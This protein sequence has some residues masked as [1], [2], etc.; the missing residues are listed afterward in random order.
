MV[1]HLPLSEMLKG[2]FV[3]LSTIRLRLVPLLNASRRTCIES[4][5]RVGAL[6]PCLQLDSVSNWRDE[7]F[8]G[9]G[10]VCQRKLVCFLCCCCGEFIICTMWLMM[11]MIYWLGTNKDTCCGLSHTSCQDFVNVR[12]VIILIQKSSVF[13]RF[14]F[15]Q[16]SRHCCIS[17]WRGWICCLISTPMQFYTQWYW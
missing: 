15:K 13:H 3:L 12:E 5:C 9:R 2:L 4:A 8:Q 6:R 17:I 16:F 10:G 7:L 14:H 1:E 11:N